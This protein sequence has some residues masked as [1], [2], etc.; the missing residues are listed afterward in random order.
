MTAISV[1]AVVAASFFLGQVAIVSGLILLERKR[2]LLIRARRPAQQ[3]GL[4]AE[5]S[6]GGPGA[7]VWLLSAVFAA[8]LTS[9]GDLLRHTGLHG[10]A[11][12]LAPLTDA[13]LLLLGPALWFFTCSVTW[14]YPA[15][16]LSWHSFSIHAIPAAAVFATLAVSAALSDPQVLDAPN[17]RSTS[18]IFGLA[19]VALHLL[20]Y[21]VTLQFRIRSTRRRLVQQVSNLSHRRLVWLSVA[22]WMLKALLALWVVSWTWDRAVSDL[23]TNLLLA[24]WLGVVGLFGIHQNNVFQF[25][26]ELRVPGGVAGDHH[27]SLG[28]EVSRRNSPPVD[29]QPAAKTPAS[30]PG[31]YAKAGL[32]ADQVQAIAE[33]LYQVM[34]EDKPY[35]DY[36]LSLADLA[37]AVG[38]TPHQL[39][40]VL[41]THLNESF[42]DHVNAWRV[43]AVKATLMR[44]QSSGRPL[45]ELA[46]EC[47]FGSKSAFNEAF[48]RVTGMSPSAYRKGLPA[49]ARSAE[50]CEIPG[51]VRPGGDGRK[52]M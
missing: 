6:A 32:G 8:A 17:E 46:L 19:P 27:V 18:E 30:V 4:G 42:Y 20:V 10:V 43:Q 36:E 12:G 29:T 21:L 35:L 47:G 50:A 3:E 34:C 33:R 1:W 25:E 16:Q 15:R 31:K 24:A 45:L 13:S 2:T 48:K 37:M 23:M 41:S 28:H 22:A 51:Q 38:C 44:P 49:T 39:S 5:A 9:L 40:Q 14:Q 26:A 7:S 52:K 11:Q